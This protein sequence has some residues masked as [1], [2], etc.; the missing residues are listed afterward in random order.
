MTD[1]RIGAPSADADAVGA[2]PIDDD[3]VATVF[4]PGTN[5][6]EKYRLKPGARLTIDGLNGEPAAIV[7]T[8]A[9]EEND[10]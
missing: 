7:E 2:E 4:V 8:D 6:W 3:G 1:A 10:A 9:T 5:G